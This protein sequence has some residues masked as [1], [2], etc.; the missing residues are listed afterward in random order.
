[1]FITSYNERSLPG[2]FFQ[3]CI[4]HSLD[5]PSEKLLIKIAENHFLAEATVNNGMFTAVAKKV[6]EMRDGARDSA[7][8]PPNT[9]EFLDAVRACLKFN[10]QPG[11]FGNVER[12]Q[13]RRPD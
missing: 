10:I 1:V 6:L 7:Q 2:A 3:R 11:D 4:I 12:Y 9:A 8:P 5:Q 13:F